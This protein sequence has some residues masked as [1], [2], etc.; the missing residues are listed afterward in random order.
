MMAVVGMWEEER[1]EY[2]MIVVGRV[3]EMA[4]LVGSIVVFAQPSHSPL[5]VS[6]PLRPWVLPRSSG[7]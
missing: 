7:D 3:M 6:L 5:W 1:W 4:L 2:S